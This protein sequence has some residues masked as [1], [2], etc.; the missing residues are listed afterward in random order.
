[1]RMTT[2]KTRV[3][4]RL[5]IFGKQVLLRIFMVGMVNYTRNTIYSVSKGIQSSLQIMERKLKKP[6]KDRMESEEC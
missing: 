4:H 6:W 5:L 3:I 1:M 2:G